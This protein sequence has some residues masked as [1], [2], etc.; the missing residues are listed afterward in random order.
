MSPAIASMPA[1]AVTAG[2]PLWTS[3]A[4]PSVSP[5]VTPSTAPVRT[6]AG[7]DMVNCEA[8]PHACGY[9]DATNT[10]VPAS[11]HLLSVPSQVSS[12]PGW[13][14]DPRGWVEV[15][16][17]GAV[18]SNLYIPYNLDISASDVTIKD[19]SVE[20]SGQ[21]WGISLR[22]THNVTIENSDV[23]SPDASGPGR[24][25]VGIKD[26][27]VDSTGTVLDADNVWHAST[28]I[29]ISEGTIENSYVHDLAYTGADHINGIA[30]DAGD[31]AGL[32]ITHNTVFN[33]DG[34]TDA[35]ALFEDFGQQYDATISDN[36][37]AGGCYTIYGG[38]N[39][40]RWIPANITITGNR[41][42]NLYYPRGGYYGPATAVSTGTNGDTW[43]GNIWDKTLKPVNWRH[44]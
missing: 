40:G 44:S 43:T 31:P 14:F 17:N 41:I 26:I 22:H 1:T 3:S 4:T 35:I 16:G 32:T 23:Y 12:G 28:G 39:A 36:L 13:R 18:L 2:A 30:S 37:L 24:L 20:V 25:Q 15:Y 34:Q 42:A 5:S 7:G 8:S 33:P 38:A 27:Y 29:Q 10:G 21:G 11:A 9:P 19:V 6:A